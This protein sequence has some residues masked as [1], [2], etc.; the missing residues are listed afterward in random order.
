MIFQAYIVFGGAKDWYSFQFLITFSK[1]FNF[2][3]K[4]L[5]NSLRS[6]TN[7][8]V[9][10]DWAATPEVSLNSWMSLSNFICLSDP[11]PLQWEKREY[12]IGPGSLD[13]IGLHLYGIQNST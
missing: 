5:V 8:G 4:T 12:D 1:Y 6:A 10:N 11:Q 9:R 13:L 3:M 2:F 7:W